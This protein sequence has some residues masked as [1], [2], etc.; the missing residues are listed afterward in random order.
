MRTVYICV[1]PF[2]LSSFFQFQLELTFSSGSFLHFRLGNFFLFFS[3][4]Q[5]DWLRGWFFFNLE[6]FDWFI[7]R[8]V[9]FVS[10]T[11]STKRDVSH[12]GG[13]NASISYVFFW[14]YNFL[15]TENFL[16]FHQCR[17]RGSVINGDDWIFMTPSFFIQWRLTSS[18]L[19]YFKSN[20]DL[21]SLTV[22]FPSSSWP[23]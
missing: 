18:L 14:N 11:E 22:I 8:G 19:P 15:L 7:S 21:S 9:F 5:F 17:A 2:F 23:D 12:F 10:G 1:F 3:L 16:S 20:D 13:A 4:E 6:W